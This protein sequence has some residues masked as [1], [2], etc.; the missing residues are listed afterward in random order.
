MSKGGYYEL[1]LFS[2]GLG[3]AS[4]KYEWLG[5][6]WQKAKDEAWSAFSRSVERG[7]KCKLDIRR[8]EFENLASSDDQAGRN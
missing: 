3:W 4:S 1:K 6:D 5:D 7:E 8:W 2:P